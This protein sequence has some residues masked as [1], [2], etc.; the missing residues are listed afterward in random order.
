MTGE[1][2]KLGLGLFFLENKELLPAQRKQC[3]ALFGASKDDSPASLLSPLLY[4][5]SLEEQN[6][7]AAEIEAYKKAL[8]HLEGLLPQLE[9]MDFLNDQLR[10]TETQL[11]EARIELASMGQSL[12]N[13][14]QELQAS[15]QSVGDLRA[16]LDH[17]IAENERLFH[18]GDQQKTE[19]ENLEKETDELGKG[20]Q[21]QQRANQKLQKKNEQLSTDL[22]HAKL[23]LQHAS[24]ELAAQQEFLMRYK[25][26]IYRLI[27]QEI[28]LT[29]ISAH[30]KKCLIEFLKRKDR[31]EELRFEAVGTEFPAYS[32]PNLLRTYR[33]C[34]REEE[35]I[36][37]QENQIYL[38]VYHKLIRQFKSELAANNRILSREEIRELGQAV[39][40]DQGEAAKA[41]FLNR[42]FLFRKLSF[43][44]EKIRLLGK[45]E[46][47]SFLGQALAIRL[48]SD[49]KKAAAYA[50]L[51]Q[52]FYQKK[53][54]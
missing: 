42:L 3:L 39:L 16:E 13:Y 49:L 21:Q 50:S 9:E 29:V 51:M 14:F 27:R 36:T 11:A 23:I 38:D 26:E 10:L 53:S 1:F 34:V 30:N 54:R 25:K 52:E 28:P 4:S 2:S 37:E 32:V 45:K 41:I 24:G 19:K 15:R 18:W 35:R 5:R 44:A 40:Q 48:R 22:E 31:G 47:S 8:K 6:R 43:L 7:K 46:T 12:E 17:R 33:N 20:L